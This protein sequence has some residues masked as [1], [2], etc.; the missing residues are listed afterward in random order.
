MSQYIGILLP[1]ITFIFSL[2]LVDKPDS[3][4]KF[5][6]YILIYIICTETLGKIISI[7]CIISNDFIYNI[8]S[9]VIYILYIQLTNMLIKSAVFKKVLNYFSII[10]ILFFIADNLWNRNLFTDLQMNTYFLGA[11]FLIISVAGFLYEI[12]NTD[13]IVIFYKLRSFW[14]SLGL[15]L[16]YVPFIPVIVCFKSELLSIDIRNIL[17]LT[18]N[19]IMH[20]CF[21][22]SF[23]CT[24]KI[25]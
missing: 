19:F 1:V 2:L 12:I 8:Y 9:L 23:L 22:I 24:K 21:I 11:I 6:R 25:I 17:T 13:K 10:L 3:Y 14:V 15:L 5:F 16:F 7:Y 18:L 4:D 20:F